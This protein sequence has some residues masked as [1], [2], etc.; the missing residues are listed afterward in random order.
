MSDKTSKRNLTAAVGAALAGSLILAGTAQGFEN[1]FSIKQLESGYMQVAGN[2]GSCGGNKA[3]EGNC[4]ESKK[5]K[6][7]SCGESGK[8]KEGSC[9]GNKAMHSETKVKEAKCGEAKC[10]ANKR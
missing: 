5:M 3:K 8:A 6:E 4:G 9:G 1:P 7:G 10:G 2:E